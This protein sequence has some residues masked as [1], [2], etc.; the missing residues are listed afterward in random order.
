MLEA[1]AVKTAKDYFRAA[2]IYQHGGDRASYRRAH[3]LAK[4]A[5]EFGSSLSNA[6]WLTA[7]SW[8]RYLLSVGST[9]DDISI[10]RS[11]PTCA[12]HT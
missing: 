6:E 1:G 11:P 2:M 10:M 5:A 3:E 12:Q 4:K 8:V 7:A 9:A